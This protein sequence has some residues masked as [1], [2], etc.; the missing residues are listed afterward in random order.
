MKKFL[1]LQVLCF[2]FVA[3]AAAATYQAKY[4]SHYDADT[5]TMEIE[6]PL[7][8]TVLAPEWVTKVEIEVQALAKVTETVRLDGLD[9]PEKGWRAKCDFERELA[10]AAR[11][12]VGDALQHADSITLV[13]EDRE[14]F[15]RILADAQIDG[16]SVVAWLIGEGYAR[17]YD[18][19]KR[20]S[21]CE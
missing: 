19:G 11:I 1:L 4:V 16:E 20:E 6:V 8:A 13:F 7:V 21:W 9:T 15:G 2:A 17:K 3:Y 5:W 18:G 12:A 10:D 14:K